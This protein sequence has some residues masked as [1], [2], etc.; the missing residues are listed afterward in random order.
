MGSTGRGGGVELS[1]VVPSKNEAEHLPDLFRSLAGQ[2][3]EGEWEVVYSDNGSTDGSVARVEQFRDRI[4]RLRI[5]EASGVIGVSHARNEGIAAA[6]GRSVAF[7]DGDDVAGGG[8]V[9]AVAESLRRHRFVASRL[10]YEEL[11]PP[12]Y[13]ALRGYT[14]RDG[15]Q[16]LW[17]PP[18]S[19]HAAGTGLGIRRDL[20]V[21]L[22]GFDEDLR[23]L[24]DTDLC[25]RAEKAGVTLHFA[26]N[27]VVHKRCRLTLGAV[28]SQ[29]RRWGRF[30]NLLFRRH[31]PDAVGLPGAWSAYFD[32]WKRIVRLVMDV[33]RLR[34]KIRRANLSWSVGWQVGLLEGS[35]RYGVPP[36]AQTE[37]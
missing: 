37:G 10:E 31:R 24:S 32:G 20:L 28:F 7:I 8:W 23:W 5:V 19:S 21:D 34:S 29:A 4:P 26:E 17:Y 16:E 30:N 14:Q 36:V 25:V 9:E 3:W 13:G 11:N 33:R 1:V 22:G 15:V 18:Y 6:R 2:S 12:G 35:F 27:G